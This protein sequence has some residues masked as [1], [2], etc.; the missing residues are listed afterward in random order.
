MCEIAI[1]DPDEH[2]HGDLIDI[3]MEIY[4][5]MR[6]SLGVLIVRDPEDVDGFRFDTYKAVEPDHVEL[7]AF[8]EGALMDDVEQ[9]I[10]HGRLATHGE[11]TVENAHPLEIECEEC[12]IDYLLHN[13]IVSRHEQLRPQQEA[14]GHNVK[15]AVDS[16]VIAHAFGDV[17]RDLENTDMSKHGYQPAFILANRE[18][19]YIR[20]S[21]YVLAENGRMARSRRE[22]APHGEEDYDAVI[23]T[24]K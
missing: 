7:S 5:T 15:T 18:A 21:R 20:S 22:F 2:S 14:E 17:P 13:G 11:I 4:S 8:L 23:M 24:P 6:S 12:D 16:E 10:I 1:L 19:V 3:S 9:V